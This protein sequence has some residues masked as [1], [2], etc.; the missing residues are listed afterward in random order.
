[1]LFGYLAIVDAFVPWGAL[2]ECLDITNK[3]SPN[4]SFECI[5]LSVYRAIKFLILLIILSFI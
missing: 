1:M 2:C 5:P 3:F 4:I